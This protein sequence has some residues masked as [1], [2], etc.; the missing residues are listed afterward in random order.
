LTRRLLLA[1]LLAS[2]PAAAQTGFAVTPA[3]T[4]AAGY[5]LT[6]GMVVANLVGNCRKFSDRLEQDPDAALAGWRRRNLA[7]ASAAES[8]LAYA[9]AAIER[10]FGAASAEEFNARTRALFQRKANTALND[11]FERTAPQFEVCAHWI[12]AIA[13]GK[14]DLNWESKYLNTL[15]ELVQFERDVRE[16]RI[17]R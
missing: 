6:H 12:A 4:E 8:Y 5:A 16:G 14:A 2:G 15:D 17:A 1:L 9:H 13:Q 3:R 7:R 11:I 10:Q